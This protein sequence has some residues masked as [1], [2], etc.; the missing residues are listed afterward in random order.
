VRWLPFLCLA[1]SLSNVWAQDQERRLID[2]LLR[3]NM[4]L[5]N[6]AQGKVFRSDS[7]VVTH[8]VAANA[9]VLEAT[10]KEKAFGDIRTVE[11]REYRSG[12]LRADAQQHSFAEI[13]QKAV[14]AQLTCSA[15]RDLHSAYDAQLQVSGR[16]F[17]DQRVF[18]DE[19]KSQKSL[20]RQNPSLTIDQVRELLNKNR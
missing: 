16:S 6:R 20:N 9:F 12:L 10:A 8:R 14:P 1:F 7:K 17:P 18:R 5:Q 3:P 19:G 13:P 11:T 15:A 2:R 4:D